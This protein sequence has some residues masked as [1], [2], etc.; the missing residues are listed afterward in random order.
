[1]VGDDSEGDKALA[2]GWRDDGR[3]R[4]ATYDL[5]CVAKGE[6]RRE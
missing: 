3:T 2:M 5:Q 1:M 6:G 4:D